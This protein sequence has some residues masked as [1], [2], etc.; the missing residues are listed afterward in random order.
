[1]RNGR[2]WRALLG[3]E[4]TVVERVE[5]DEA[6]TEPTAVAHVRPVAAQRSRCGVCRRRCPGYDAGAGRRRWRSLDLGTVQV[7]MEAEAPRVHCPDHGVVVAAVPWARHGAGHTYG[8]DDQVAWL[9]VRCSKSA[10]RTLMRI[11]WRTVGTIVTRVAADAR[12]GHDH[13][14]GLRRIGIDEISYKKGHRYLT[15]VVDHDTRRLVWAAP[16]KDSA[17]LLR[18]FDALGPDRCA[19]ISHVSADAANWIAVAVAERCPN[20]V[21]CADPFHVVAWATDA[22]DEVRRQAWRD[23]YALARTEP[24]RRRGRPPAGAPPRPGHA[25]TRRIRHARYALWKNPENLTDTQRDKLAWVAKT[26]PRLYRAYLL[27]EGLRH[28]FK[29]K[30][31]DGKQALDRWLSWAAR[32]RIPAFVTLA[33]SI[34]AHR[35]AID[36]TLDHNLSNALIE[37]TNTKIRLLTRMAFGFHSPHALVALAMLSLGGYC[38]PLPGRTITR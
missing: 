3:V 20:A 10:V 21:R 11:A 36:A 31:D 16:G 13:L 6:A 29:V 37:S 24:K 5:L 25:A 28:V 14:A 17:T 9:A 23:A 27:K 19:Q 7:V 34:R 15:V 2:L 35:P 1:M 26:D 18:F 8:F 12:A 32:C 30:G 4:R 22:L 33:R 38:P